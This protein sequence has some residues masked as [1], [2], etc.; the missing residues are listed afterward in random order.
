V[1]RRAAF[2]A[3]CAI[4]AA[5]VLVGARPAPSSQANAPL[6]DALA[7]RWAAI[8]DY[9]ATIVAHEVDGDRVEDRAMHF[10]F[11]KPDRAKLQMTAG[12][13][14]GSVLIW[15]GGSN[16][17]AM[18]GFFTLSFDLHSPA[19]NSIR[20]NTILRPDLTLTLAC[21][22]SH[23]DAVK[24]APGPEIAGKQTHTLTLAIAG[25][26]GCPGDSA[27]DHDV[28]RD[29]LT[30]RDDDNLVVLRERYV[31]SSVVEHWELHDV[32]TNVGLSDDDFR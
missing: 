26:L 13:S 14:A 11:R 6:L 18:V 29:V 31:G 32:R 25:G 2:T 24:E 3:A 21:F 16:V 12:G 23:R 8:D 7:K 28:D 22:Q 20:G 27:T 10:W 15:R 9:T 4:L 1:T 19:I 17:R 30:L 5:C